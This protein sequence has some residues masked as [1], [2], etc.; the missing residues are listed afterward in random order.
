MDLIKYSFTDHLLFLRGNDV[1]HTQLKK[2]TF[3]K[4]DILNFVTFSD[5]CFNLFSD[6]LKILK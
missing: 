1:E 4:K 5:K 6:A 2:I 3:K